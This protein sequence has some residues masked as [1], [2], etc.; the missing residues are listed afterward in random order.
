M[1]MFKAAIKAYVNC[2]QALNR[3]SMVHKLKK[4]RG[5]KEPYALYI[6][7]RVHYIYSPVSLLKRWHNKKA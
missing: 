6:V 2:S 5:A 4:I 7:Q 3:I 1:K